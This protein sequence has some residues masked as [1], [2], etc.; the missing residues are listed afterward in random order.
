MNTK[1]SKEAVLIT[2]ASSGLGKVFAE[3]FAE[4]GYNLVLVARREER[5]ENLATELSHTFG[6]EVKSIVADLGSET[7]LKKVE[8]Y[9]ENDDSISILINNAGT[10]TIAPLA[11][12]SISKQREM[13][14]VNIIAL[15]R[16]SNAILPQ[17]INRK[18]GNLINI[19]SILGYHALSGSAIYSGTKAFVVQYTRGLQEELK[20]TDIVVQLVCP[21]TTATEIWDV[22]G[23]GLSA[24]DKSTIMTAD[25]C[26]E[27]AIAG[28]EKRE[29]ITFPSIDDE[30]VINDYETARMNLLKH[31][32][33][34][35]P[36]SRYQ[37]N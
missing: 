36:A 26:V 34:G 13:I 7:G 23:I 9:L 10:S 14:D 17:F 3:K 6:N 16:L 27:A 30:Q 31:S 4:R 12:T 35:K 18:K 20:D 33:S 37:I 15:M 1:N 28:L 24:L 21:A 25:N 22:S 5:L 19:A 8:D 11:Q 2:G 32:Q 29:L